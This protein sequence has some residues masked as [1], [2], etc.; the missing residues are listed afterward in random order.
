MD[1]KHYSE[2]E[3]RELIKRCIGFM[4]AVTNSARADYFRHQKHWH[5]EIPYDDVLN[6]MDLSYSTLQPYPEPVS[7]F[8]LEERRISDALSKLTLLQRRILTLRYIYRFHVQEIADILGCS[9]EF[10]Y[11]HKHRAIK[12]LRDDILRGGEPDERH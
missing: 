3:D 4:V 6:E 9:V 2:D 5:K 1:S 10:V 8:E 11:R 12:K 7:D